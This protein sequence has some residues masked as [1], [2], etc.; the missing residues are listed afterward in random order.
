MAEN[1][2]SSTKAVPKMSPSE[3]VLNGARPM[4]APTV[5]PESVKKEVN[6]KPPQGVVEP[7][8]NRENQN[9]QPQL[10]DKQKIEKGVDEAEKDNLAQEVFDNN[11]GLGFAENALK[12]GL[13][14][15]LHQKG[16]NIDSKKHEEQDY[17]DIQREEEGGD[18]KSLFLCLSLL[19]R[20]INIALY[21]F[22]KGNCVSLH[23]N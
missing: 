10:E 1:P 14:N 23:F 4:N 8:E 12:P 7:P 3:G 13:S 6:L 19:Y 5:T 11:E 9:E 20:V 21:R 15:E 2:S 18:G 16:I 22:T 17:K